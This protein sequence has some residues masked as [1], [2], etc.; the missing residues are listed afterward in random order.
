MV[1]SFGFKENLIDN[2]IYVKFS[3]SKF[4]ILILHMDDILLA[5]NNKDMLF[6]TKSFLSGNFEMKDL[7]EASFVLGIQI[8]RDRSRG[9]LG[10][11]QH[12]HIEKALIRYDMQNCTLG[13]TSVCKG[14]KFNL[15]QCS[16]LELEIKEIEQFSDTS[17]VGSLMYAQVCT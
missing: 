6:Q 1:T 9:I 16:R 13:D 11:S 8:Y 15:Q 12:T 10:L 7:G 17:S 14:D 3:G 2:C 4:V 5:S